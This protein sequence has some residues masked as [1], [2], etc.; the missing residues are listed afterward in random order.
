MLSG[1]SL[2]E[3]IMNKKFLVLLLLLIHQMSFA[4][5]PRPAFQSPVCRRS[6]VEAL[7]RI[8]FYNTLGIFRS[9]P[10]TPQQTYSCA[11]YGCN[12]AGTTCRTNCT[13]DTQC[14]EGSV[15][16][17]RTTKCVPLTYFCSEDRLFAHGTDG[18]TERCDPYRCSLGR[19]NYYC[20]SEADCVRPYRCSSEGR[21]E[22]V[23]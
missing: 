22:I 1:N 6:C 19:C 16:N 18:S 17:E 13:D 7:G 10:G 8:T 2:P 21:C 11:P 9:C 23:K 14:S 3:V 4:Q 20:V 5:I 15:C 12:T